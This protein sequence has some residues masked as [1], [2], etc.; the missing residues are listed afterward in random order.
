MNLDNLKQILI[1]SKIFVKDKNK[2]FLCI[3]CYCGDHKNP[4]KRGHLYVSKDSKIPVCHCWYCGYSVPI[5]KLISDL[6]GDRTKYQTVITDEELQ[7]SSKV[8]K[9]I[10]S[11]KRFE[12]YKIPKLDFSS[13]ENKKLYV[14]RR[15]NNSIDIETI[16]NLV[17]NFLEFFN[18]NK[19]D[20]VGEKN[21]ITDYE[22]DMLQRNFIGFLS[23]HNTTLYCRSCDDSSNFKFKKVVLQNETF[24]L[25]DYWSLKV[26]DPKRNTVVLTEG[27]FNALGEFI[28]DSLKIKDQVKV[29]A[30]GNT[31]SYGQ[32]LKSVCFDHSIYKASVII[33]SDNDKNTKDYSWFLKEHDHIIKDC[34]I[35]I[36]KNGKDFGE[37]PQKPIQIL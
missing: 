34:K 21:I 29:Y 17:F 23:E 18:I 31:F 32:L 20:V 13:F 3:C 35:Y 24:G 15:T 26:D 9:K 1:Q 4:A 5:S 12:Q 33:L 36:N 2:N 14:K 6:T 11:K 19:L 27:N 30:S 28:T 7:K 8:Q 25:L 22:V 10:S 37:Y 16:P